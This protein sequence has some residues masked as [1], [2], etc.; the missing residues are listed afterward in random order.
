MLT[1]QNYH[2]HCLFQEQILLGVDEFQLTNCNPLNSI[3]P[4][5]LFKRGDYKIKKM[6]QIDVT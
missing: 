3:F 2:F 5:T 4:V 6:Y 1:L